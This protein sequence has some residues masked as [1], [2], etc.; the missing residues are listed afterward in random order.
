MSSISKPKKTKR[1]TKRKIPAG[2]VLRGR[3]YH[4]DFMKGGRRIRKRLSTDLGAAI[5]LLN[6]LRHRADKADFDLLDNRY[7]W[8]DLRKDFLAWAKQNVRGWHEYETD[9]DKFE[10]FCW[11]Q[12]VSQI[13]PT[14]VIQ[15]RNWRMGQG[16]T[17][18]TINKQVGTIRN[19]LA[20]GVHLFKVIASN[21]LAELERLSEGDPT[22]VRRPLSADEVAAIFKHAPDDLKLMFRVYCTTG[23]RRDEVVGLRFSD[24]DWESQSLTVRAS[25]AKSGKAREVPIDDETMQGLIGLREAATGRPDGWDREH[26]FVNRIG[27]PHRNTLLER[28]YIVCKRAGITDGVPNGSVDLH[29]LRGTFISLS[30]EHGGSVK[31]VQTIVGHS[32]P[33]LTMNVYAKATDKAKRAAVSALPF[34]QASAPAHVVSIDKGRE[35]SQNSHNC[36]ERENS[37]VG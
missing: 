16:V 7:P 15:F 24:I 22:K 37:K 35:L 10:E 34:A 6:A 27:Q 25:V 18:R 33:N 26:V 3:T 32:T 5:E 23:M 8:A 9:L 21:A 36:S 31:A 20:K 13:T 1:R 11:V 2:M 4:A 19:M 14:L 28:F 29:A 17:P 12:S 30:L